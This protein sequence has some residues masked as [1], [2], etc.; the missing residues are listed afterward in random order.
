VLLKVSLGT[1]A[2]RPYLLA[3]PTVGLLR[4]ARQRLHLGDTL[5]A[6]EDVMEDTRK[7]D[8]GVGA[9][10]GLAVPA[11]P[12]QLFAEAQYVFGLTTSTRPT[13]T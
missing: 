6:D 9:G 4:R 10:G 5:I 1:G 11:G 3:G 12:A 13:R 2:L 8:F 7:L